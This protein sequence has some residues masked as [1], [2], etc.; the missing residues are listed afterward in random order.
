MFCRRSA[1]CEGD[2]GVEEFECASL[3]VGG[4]GEG[5]HDWSVVAVAQVVSGEGGQVFEIPPR[6]WR[7]QL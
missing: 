6:P 2:G 5:G 3:G 7:H 4:C 1:Q